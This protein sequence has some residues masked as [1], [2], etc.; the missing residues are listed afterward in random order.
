MVPGAFMSIVGNNLLNQAVNELGI[1]RP[2]LI[3]D[4]M[5][6]GLARLVKNQGDFEFKDGMDIALFAYNPKT[7]KLQL[8]GA[9]NPVWI[10][11]HCEGGPA[12]E[13]Y[14]GDKKPI[15]AF[16][17]GNN[18][19]FTNHELTVMPGDSI[20]LFSDGYADQFG[21]EK[22]KKF[23]KSRLKELLMTMQDKSMGQQRSLLE[24]SFNSWRGEYEQVDDV[25]VIGIKI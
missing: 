19:L 3:L 10:V 16:A 7:R 11:R 22:G 1:S 8:A 24:E 6:K 15:G 23:K 21:G 14:K 12:F 4:Q 20:Y 2:S 5:N 18:T 17:T 13:E 25:L 9:N